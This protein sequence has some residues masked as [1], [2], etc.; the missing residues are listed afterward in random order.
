LKGF[1]LWKSPALTHKNCV[2]NL[3]YHTDFSI[4]MTR[5][6]VVE[7][8]KLYSSLWKL[9]FFFDSKIESVMQP[10]DPFQCFETGT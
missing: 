6:Y 2:A 9:T 5:Q 4:N 8:K 3:E 10:P 1:S 7:A